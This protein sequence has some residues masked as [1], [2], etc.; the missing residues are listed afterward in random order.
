[1][2]SALIPAI[3]A[4]A[5]YFKTGDWKTW[6]YEAPFWVW[7]A[8][9]FALLIWIATALIRTR[10]KNMNSDGTTIAT[11]SVARH[12]REEVGSLNHADVKWK[13]MVA[14]PGMGKSLDPQNIPPDR[15]KIETPPRCPECEAK[16]EEKETFFA[17]Y[18]WSCVRC[19]FNTKNSDNYYAE[20]DRAQ[21]LAESIYEEE[22]DGPV[23]RG[24]WLS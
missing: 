24:G 14:L 16:L 18:K 21:L 5:S 23:R 9:V 17:R 13:I 10:L 20:R 2:A 11:A 4:A 15:I 22:Y 3:V 7:P 12:G 8:L 6:F 1:M 19:S